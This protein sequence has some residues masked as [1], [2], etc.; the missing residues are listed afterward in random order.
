[1][2]G[3]EPSGIPGSVIVSKE[4]AIGNVLNYIN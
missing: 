3:D 1:V 2:S 4:E